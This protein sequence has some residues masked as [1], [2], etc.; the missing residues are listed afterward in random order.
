[1]KK[2]SLQSPISLTLGQI[3]LLNSKNYMFF[4]T[5]ANVASS[6][7]AKYFM[8]SD[9]KGEEIFAMFCNDRL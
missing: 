1:M 6:D 9:Q 7:V 8:S 3:H 4:I 5:A 2:L